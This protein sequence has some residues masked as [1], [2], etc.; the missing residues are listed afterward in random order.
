[1]GTN[2]WLGGP[3]PGTF[4][5]D[6]SIFSEIAR[7]AGNHTAQIGLDAARAGNTEDLQQ[8]GLGTF[9]A[10]LAAERVTKSGTFGLGAFDD[11]FGKPK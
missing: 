2:D 6:V 9:G 1:M 7:R 4:G 11:I 8:S 3:K 10:N 5:G